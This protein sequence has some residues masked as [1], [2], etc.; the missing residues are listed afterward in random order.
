M[1][2]T[3]EQWKSW[4]EDGVLAV[5]AAVVGDELDRLRAAFASRAGEAKVDWLTGVAAG[6]H[7]AAFFDIPNAMVCPGENK[8]TTKVV[9]T[10]TWPCR[11]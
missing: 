11:R 6:T 2:A 7:P 5:P 1:R 9:H 10:S 8:P 4:E 3:P